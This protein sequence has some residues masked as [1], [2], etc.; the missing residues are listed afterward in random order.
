MSSKIGA[1]IYRYHVAGGS[2]SIARIT[3][4]AAVAAAI[5]RILSRFSFILCSFMAFV[6]IFDK[7][8]LKAYREQ[9]LGGLR[10]KV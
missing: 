9:V 8:G 3:I 5:A 10:H 4:K 6:F 1:C 7:V 2:K